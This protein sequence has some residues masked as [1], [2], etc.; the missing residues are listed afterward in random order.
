M[1]TMNDDERQSMKEGLQNVVNVA[2]GASERS[3]GMLQLD[4][5]GEIIGAV[6]SVRL[7]R[8]MPDVLRKLFL[9]LMKEINRHSGTRL[10][11]EGKWWVPLKEE[12]RRG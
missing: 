4:R 10:K 6:L 3:V 8:K 2:T 5:D 7:D 9:E 1:R 11:K 12:S